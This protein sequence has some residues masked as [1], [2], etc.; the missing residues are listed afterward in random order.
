[1]HTCKRVVPAAFRGFTSLS[2]PRTVRQLTP[3][4][5]TYSHKRYYSVAQEEVDDL[6]QPS[7]LD[8]ATHPSTHAR[9][10]SDA[11]YLLALYPRPNLIFSHGKGPHLYDLAGREYLDLAAGIAV[12]ALGHGDEEVQQIVADQAGKLIHLSNL[13]H[14]EYA[15]NFA[16]DLVGTLKVGDKGRMGKG[17]KVF[18]CNSGTEANEAAI[19]FIRKWG[20]HTAASG[21]SK[22]NIVSF[23]NAFHGRTLGALSAT[24]S[25]KYQAPFAPLVPGF[26]NVPYNNIEAAKAAITEETCGVIVEP[27]QGEGGIFEGAGDFLKAIRE[28]CDEVGALLV[29]DEI[30]SGLGRTGKLWAYEH[31]GVVP[32]IISVAKPLANGIPIGAVLLSPHIAEIIKPGDH[33]T[34]FG[35]NPLATRVGHAVFKRISN[36][37]FLSH[38]QELGSYLKSSCEE[39]ASSTPLITEVRGVG[40]MIGM[41][42]RDSVQPQMFVDLCRERGVLV[43]SAGNN[44]IRLVPPLV[45]Q[46]GDV[47]KAVKVF[48]DVLGEMESYIASGKA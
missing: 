5:T 18:F 43:I 2:R 26:S 11:Q 7:H 29:F 9:L 39:L 23:G 35:G 42:L 13:Y 34:T 14:N 15:G 17:T 40:L 4:S 36:P 22:H 32:D 19:K 33:G 46:K 41:Q 21:A 44:T 8:A 6:S 16:K 37:Q 27:V 25:P 20:K 47:D 45:L 12:N 28:R 30:Q 31:V 3:L 38:V 24:P 10:A 48:E 1:M